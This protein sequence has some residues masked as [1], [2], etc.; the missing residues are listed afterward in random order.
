MNQNSIKRPLGAG[1][2]GAASS[3]GE[4]VYLNLTPL[5]DVMSNILFFL[6]TAFGASAIAVFS[7]TVPVDSAT[8]DVAQSVSPEQLSVT[9]K[10]AQAGLTV[11][12][13][14][15]VEAVQASQPSLHVCDDFIAKKGLQH[16]TAAL[17]QR[18]L[19]IKAAFPKLRTLTVMPEDALKYKVLVQLLDATREGGTAAG[20]RQ[21]LFSDV[22][23]AHPE[24]EPSPHP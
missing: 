24:P 2:F 9:L 8:H 19:A 14:G 16:D 21:P 1:M 23:L 10:V 20:Q 18:M 5:M 4:Q 11:G 12:C 7:I 3:H 22:V 6:L 13:V 17:T 15:S